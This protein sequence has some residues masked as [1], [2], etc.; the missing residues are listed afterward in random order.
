[1]TLTRARLCL[2]LLIVVVS[3]PRT[4]WAQGPTRDQAVEALRKAVTFFH[5]RVAVNG[6]YV[7]RVSGDL[8]L[9]EGE[10]IAGPKTIWVQPPGTPAVGEAFLD[11]YD[12]TGDAL[13][14]DAARD[15][16]R[17][18]V[19][20]QLHSGGWT[21][22]IEF[23]P[24]DREE[25]A[26]RLDLDGQ[27]RPDPTSKAPRDEPPGWDFWKRRKVK[28]NL[29]T[30]DDDTTQAATRFL[31]RLD[32]ALGFQD[33]PIHAAAGLAVEAI[34]GAQYPNGGWSVSFDRFP[35][36][37]PG[38]VDYPPMRASYP[39][40]WPRTWPKDFTG[41][42]VLNDDLMADVVDTLLLAHEVYKNPRDLEAAERA[43][44]FLL[45]AQMPAPQPAW[46]QQYDK[47][48]QPVWSRAF[49]PPAVTGGESQGVMET[50][51]KL[52][53]VTGNLQYLAPIPEALAYLRRVTLPD[54]RL[55][56]FAELRTDRPIYFARMPVGPHKMIFTPEGMATHYGFLVN[57]R[58]DAIEASYRRLIE[59]QPAP[60]ARSR[61]KES[62]RRAQLAIE[63]LDDRGAWVDRGRL[64]SHKVEPASGVVDSQT[65]ARN[66]A[67]LT[68]FLREQAE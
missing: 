1:M 11:A 40:D 43:G 8:T 31:I 13:H 54:G 64:T 65:F 50:L 35:R 26:Y 3:A 29:S 23:D 4:L 6:G 61:S 20:G 51:I 59:A 47:S 56:R 5:Q 63:S 48:M 28:G 24:K 46:A 38:A 33:E 14:R 44:G 19:L 55:A 42:Y 39:E 66:V 25:F 57:Q 27:P 21:Y 32:R 60:A 58:L 2:A 7:Y 34:R 16:G 41:C 17:A 36:T 49:E 15:A 53:R 9:R 67:A 22:R 68:R 18:L 52:A 30:L 10:G 45:L 62:A 12:A 37:P